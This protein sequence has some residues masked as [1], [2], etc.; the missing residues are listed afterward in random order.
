M[1]SQ[2]TSG[3][4]DQEPIGIY[5]TPLID[6]QMD[7]IKDKN[8]PLLEKFGSAAL[9]VAIAQHEI[10]GRG[11]VLGLQSPRSKKFTYVKQSDSATALWMTAVDMKR[12][13]AETLKQYSPQK[14][15]VIVMVVP[16]TAQLYLAS[17]DKQLE[18][19]EIQQVEQTT[20]KLPPW[21]SSRKEQRGQTTYYVF[22]HKTL[23][24]LGRIALTPI[25]SSQMN[26]AHEVVNPKGFESPKVH[27]QRLGI[28]LPLAQEIIARLELG[29]MQ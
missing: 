17:Q 2:S 16:P 25:T 5:I 11:M 10:H 6:E 12:K 28:F 7:R 4:P 9:Q 26:I 27:Q 1:T 22:A 20:L 29:L 19:L 3:N 24:A 15:A 23:G 21:V 18:I 13:V 8:M 14:N